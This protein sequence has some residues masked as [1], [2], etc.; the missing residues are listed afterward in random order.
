M[1]LAAVGEA[2]VFAVD[3]LGVEELPLGTD[4][5]LLFPSGADVEFAGAAV[6]VSFDIGALLGAKVVTLATVG[7]AVPLELCGL[8]VVPSL[9]GADVVPG[10][11]VVSGAE[12]FAS[13]AAVVE[14][15]AK[16]PGTA[17]G[18]GVG[19]SVGAAVGWGVGTGVGT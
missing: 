18:A 14:L 6:V 16:V 13:G 12:V 19:T 5:P 2:V 11:V 7:L 4:V 9:L 3:G 1:A 17:V 8:I 15:G 10:A